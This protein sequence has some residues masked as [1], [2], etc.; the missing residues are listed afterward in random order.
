L[1]LLAESF[2]M[3]VFGV[4]ARWCSCCVRYRGFDVGF[5]YDFHCPAQGSMKI[6]LKPTL[7]PRSRMQ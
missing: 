2:L 3:A 7:N 5:T 6:K 1:N 4:L